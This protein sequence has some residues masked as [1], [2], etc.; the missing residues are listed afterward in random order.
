MMLNFSGLIEIGVCDLA[1]D[2][3][4]FINQ[5]FLLFRQNQMTPSAL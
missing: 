4:F 3:I 2:V 1:S 5:L